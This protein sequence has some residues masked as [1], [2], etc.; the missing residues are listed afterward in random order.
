MDCYSNCEDQTNDLFVTTSN[1]PNRKTFKV[2]E[3]D[4][5]YFDELRSNTNQIDITGPRGVLHPGKEAAFK[6]LQLSKGVKCLQ[7]FFINFIN[8][9]DLINCREF[10]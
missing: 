7:I 5:E 2:D 10:H 9:C 4:D 8:V 6:Y 3:D 1:Y